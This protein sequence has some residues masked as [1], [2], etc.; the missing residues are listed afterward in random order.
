MQDLIVFGGI[1]FLILFGVPLFNTLKDALVFRI[2]GV[3][4]SRDDRVRADAHVAEDDLFQDDDFLF[5]DRRR[6]D[7]PIHGEAAIRHTFDIDSTVMVS[8][9]DDM[10][11]NACGM[12]S[13]HDSDDCRRDDPI[14]WENDFHHCCNIDGSPMCGD[15]DIHGNPYG[16]TE[17]HQF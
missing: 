17:L 10:N 16:V 2:I 7:N 4:S 5:W 15:T 8:H 13:A 3:A 9:F 12:T 14:Q 1:T 6:D 11:G